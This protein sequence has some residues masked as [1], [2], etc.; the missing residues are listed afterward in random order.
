MQGWH[1]HG[2]A[3]TWKGQ[4]NIFVLSLGFL[5]LGKLGF[6]YL[7]PKHRNIVGAELHPVGKNMNL[8]LGKGDYSWRNLTCWSC[9]EAALFNAGNYFQEW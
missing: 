5:N 9:T 2:A 8:M 1:H 7:C 6:N 3:G 4:E